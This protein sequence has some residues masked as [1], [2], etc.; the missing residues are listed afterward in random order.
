MIIDRPG[1]P[2][3]GRYLGLEAWAR[4]VASYDALVI[5][6]LFQTREYATALIRA[7]HPSLSDPEVQR[8]VDL[9]MERQKVLIR[10]PEP[11]QLWSVLDEAALRRPV[12]GPKVMR[13]QLAHLVKRAERPNIDLQVLPLD[14][15][16]H[17]G[18]DGTF[19]V[20]DFPLE[21]PGDP[22]TVYVQN[23]LKGVYYEEPV[24]IDEYRQILTRLRAEAITPTESPL[25]IARIAEETA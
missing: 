5:R 11:L 21:L 7:G 1:E 20:L 25:V 6:G 4:L 24:E 8:R 16:A 14:S 19:T 15:G 10:E 9:R 17:A 13:A 12:G 2:L 18:L 22:G 23:R 3:L